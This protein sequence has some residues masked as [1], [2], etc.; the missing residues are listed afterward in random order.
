LQQLQQQM[1]ELSTAPVL[2]PGAWCSLAPAFANPFLQA[3]AVMPGVTPGGLQ[4]LPVPN[5]R[6][7]HYCSGGKVRPRIRSVGDLMQ[8]W[9]ACHQECCHPTATSPS[10]SSSFKLQ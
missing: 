4:V 10:G 2:R 5:T 8:A 3:H 1:R 9:R 7:P 6:G